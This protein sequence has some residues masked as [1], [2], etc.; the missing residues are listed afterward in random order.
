MQDAQ[1]CHLIVNNII[2]TRSEHA[3]A[4]VD[5]PVRTLFSDS[6]PSAQRETI[7]T[8]HLHISRCVHVISGQSEY[9]NKTTDYLSHSKDAVLSKVLSKLQA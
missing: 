4:Q 1:K 6:L 5:H 9:D 3:V 7:I 8:S 2:D